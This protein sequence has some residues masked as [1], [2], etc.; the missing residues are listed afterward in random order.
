MKCF[1][2]TNGMQSSI[3]QYTLLFNLFGE[4]LPSPSWPEFG[5]KARSIPT[6]WCL[7]LILLTSTTPVASLIMLGS[8]CNWLLLMYSYRWTSWETVWR[9]SWNEPNQKTLFS[10]FSRLMGVHQVGLRA[11]VLQI[12]SVAWFLILRQCYARRLP[13]SSDDFG[14]SE[15][16]SSYYRPHLRVSIPNPQK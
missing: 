6:F 15:W 10:S 11:V 4:G 5:G 9:V 7:H 2:V 3:P 16:T 1:R 8:L 13:S 14:V 12:P